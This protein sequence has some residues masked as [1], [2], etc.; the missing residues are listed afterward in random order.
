MHGLSVRLDSAFSTAL[1]E[2]LFGEAEGP[3]TG[4]RVQLPR[5]DLV[6]ARSLTYG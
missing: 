5:Q 1:H 6:T 4:A 3:R 2:A